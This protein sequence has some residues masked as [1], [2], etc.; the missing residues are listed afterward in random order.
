M[1]K[2]FIDFTRPIGRKVLSHFRD[3]RDISIETFDDM[4]PNVE[5]TTLIEP[6]RIE[7]VEL[8]NATLV[9]DVKHYQAPHFD[10]PRAFAAILRNVLYCPFNNVILNRDGEV[11]A[12]SM[13]TIRR[14]EYLDHY[15]LSASKIIR[16]DQPVTPL[17]SRFNH[18]YH[19][20]IDHAPRLFLLQAPFFQSFDRIG[21]LLRDGPTPLEELLVSRMAPSN[22]HPLRLR[23][24]VLYEFDT[25]LFTSFMTRRHAGYLPAE[26]LRYVSDRMLPNRPRERKNRIYI[27]RAGNSKGRQVL[28]EE[29]VLEAL[30]PF[31]FRSYRLQDLSYEDQ[32]HLFYDAEAVVGPHGAG[33]SNLLW[34][35]RAFV[36]EL[37]PSHHLVPSFY[38]LSASRNHT[39]RRMHSTGAWRDD[40]FNVDLIEMQEIMHTHL[41]PSDT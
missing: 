25:L 19:T 7:T 1:L 14:T 24:R 37:F 26:Y 21:L 13:S 30:R 32:I 15:A 35:D 17:R 38:F 12:E 3:R 20:L 40:D 31:G 36:L 16:I 34:A 41:S 6:R 29:A 18:Y 4:F 28:N 9:P 11:L 23:R 8:E 22:V 33:F 10:S 39:Y 27:S 2:Q 5:K